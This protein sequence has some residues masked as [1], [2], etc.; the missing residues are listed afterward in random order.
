MATQGALIRA[1]DYNT[2]Q[3]NIANI[4]GFGSGNFGYGQSLTSSQVTA[5]NLIEAQDWAKL[6]I[7]MLKIAS[8]QGTEGNALITSLPSVTAGSEIQDTDATA[9]ENAVPFLTSNRF[10]LNEFSDEA[11]SPNISQVRTT[12]WGSPAKPTVRHSFTVDFGNANNA[13]YFF[14]SGSSI[15]FSASFTG[16]NSDPQNVAWT[17]LLSAMGTVVYNYAGSTAASGTSSAI[18]FYN[19]TNVA[20][21]VFTK[22]GVGVTPTV[23]AANDYTITMSCDVADNTTGTARYIYVSVYFNDD[24]TNPFSDSVNGTL[25][26]SVSVRRAS[27]T[28]VNVAIPSATN[29]VLLTS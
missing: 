25:T 23:Y 24:H 11:F 8:H 1:I 26:H 4:L 10:L 9:F 12:S 28:N 19:L 6:K 21:P 14:N 7:D 27:G 20:Q 13:R 15:R 22:S 16:V 2:I 5:G 18:G 29:T 17:N 3:L